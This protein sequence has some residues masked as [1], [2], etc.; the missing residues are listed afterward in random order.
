MNEDLRAYLAALRQRGADLVLGWSVRHINRAGERSAYSKSAAAMLIDMQRAIS[1]HSEIS[2]SEAE[3]LL[4]YVR[5]PLC[6]PL[7]PGR[8]WT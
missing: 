7:L 5:L 8:G 4:R 2:L 3:S 1:D 6:L